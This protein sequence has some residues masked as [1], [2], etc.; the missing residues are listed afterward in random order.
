MTRFFVDP[1]DISQNTIKL[2]NDDITHIRSLRLKLEEF[3][4]VCDGENNDY[5]CKLSGKSG[6]SNVEI[7]EKQQSTGEPKVKCKVFLA[8]ARAFAHDRQQLNLQWV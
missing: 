4:I 7:I 1:S 5:I 8:Y 3:F 6:N 2:C